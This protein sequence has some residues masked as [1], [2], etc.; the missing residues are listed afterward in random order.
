VEAEQAGRLCVREL[1]LGQA[2]APHPAEFCENGAKATAWELT[3]KRLPAAFF[4]EHAVTELLGWAITTWK[5]AG[6]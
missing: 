1:R 3:A 2:R 4:E 6:A 5:P